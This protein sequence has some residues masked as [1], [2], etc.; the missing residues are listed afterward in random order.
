M[1]PN[2]TM[3]SC[4]SMVD[5]WKASP[6]TRRP[7]SWRLSFFVAD[8]GSHFCVPNLRMIQIS[9]MID[10]Q[11]AHF[12]I[13]HIDVTT[14]NPNHRNLEGQNYIVFLFEFSMAQ[15]QAQNKTSDIISVFQ[16]KYVGPKKCFKISSFSQ[17]ATSNHFVPKAPWWSTPKWPTWPPCRAS[18]RPPAATGCRW[19]RRSPWG[20][21]PPE[22]NHQG[23]K[24]PGQGPKITMLLI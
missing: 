2:F 13:H 19:P 12:E 16:Q 3:A 1:D 9:K 6:G 23:R 10:V 21:S 15:N 8:F 22:K 14:I 4:A 24:K 20:R 7:R 11:I 18:A 5:T 17:G